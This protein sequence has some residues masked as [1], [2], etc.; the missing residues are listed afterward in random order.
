ML[1]PEDIVETPVDK[2]NE[3]YRNLEKKQGQENDQNID[4]ERKKQTREEELAALKAD[5]LNRYRFAPDPELETKIKQEMGPA[6]R[7]EQVDQ[8]AHEAATSPLNDKPEPTEAQ[9]KAGNYPK[10]HVRIHGL[11]VSIENPKGSVRSGKDKNGKPWSVT[12][13]SHYGYIKQS[14]GADKEHIDVFI[15]P[16][17][18]SKKVYIVDQVNPETG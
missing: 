18:E 14:K 7:A 6:S 4:A 2:L 15:G 3:Y 12:M 5:I 1:K 17:P 9:I 13:Q 10:G 11:D 8:A 16:N